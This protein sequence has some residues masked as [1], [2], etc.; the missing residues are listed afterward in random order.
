MAIS[1]KRLTGTELP[2]HFRAQGLAFAFQIVSYDG[3]VTY[4]KSEVE[5]AALVAELHREDR[6]FGG[7]T[8]APG[9][10]E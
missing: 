3:S 10:T 8:S 4:V 1:F 2:P 9:E 6:R 5:A 7:G